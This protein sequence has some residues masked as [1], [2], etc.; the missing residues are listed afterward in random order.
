MLCTL[1]VLLGMDN[2][3]LERI[4]YMEFPSTRKAEGDQYFLQTALKLLGI[5]NL[6][7]RMKHRDAR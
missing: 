4:K 5:D 1:A 2:S 7:L 3:F 6:A